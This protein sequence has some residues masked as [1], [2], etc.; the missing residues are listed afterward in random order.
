MRRLDD[1][2]TWITSGYSS[3]PDSSCYSTEE[4]EQ[5]KVIDAHSSSRYTVTLPTHADKT[6]VEENWCFFYVI[7]DRPGISYYSC[8]DS[9]YSRDDAT[10]TVLESFDAYY[11]DNSIRIEWNLNGKGPESG[12]HVMRSEGEGYYKDLNQTVISDRSGFY[13]LVDNRIDSGKA[14]QYR[15]LYNE[16]GKD[17]ILFETE[18]ILTPSIS[19]SLSQNNPNPF[20]PSTT[21]N[22]YIAAASEVRLDVFDVNGKLVRNLVST[23]LPAGSYTAKWDARSDSGALLASG[24]YFCRLQGGKDSITKKM[25]LLK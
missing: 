23:C 14:Y 8:P 22:Y 11:E 2:S 20:N 17:R 3:N 12:F 4:W 18:E 6:P 1:P 19:V 24:V 16:E 5:I 15:I 21:I 7:A 10:A 9:G 13:F 25:I